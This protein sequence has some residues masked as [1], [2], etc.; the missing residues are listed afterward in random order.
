MEFGQGGNRG[1]LCAK[2][3]GNSMGV[4]VGPLMGRAR[5]M[6]VDGS[7]ARRARGGGRGE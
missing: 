5:G 6:V 2:V 3:H 1:R 4:R 7:P